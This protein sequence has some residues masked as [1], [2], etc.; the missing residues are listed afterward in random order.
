MRH[1]HL[2]QPSDNFKLCS[3]FEEPF[4]PSLNLPSS[5]PPLMPLST[6]KA[7]SALIQPQCSASGPTYKAQ[8]TKSNRIRKSATGQQCKTPPHEH[9]Y[10]CPAEGCERC[11]SC[12]DDLTRHVRVHTGQK[13][14]QCRICM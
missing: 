1:K 10:A 13:P 3:S 12:S 4:C 14:F 5:Q 2:G 8:C 7:F 11:F 9:P 6:I